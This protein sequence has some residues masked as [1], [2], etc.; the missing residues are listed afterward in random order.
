VRSAPLRRLKTWAALAALLI[1]GCA[2]PAAPPA[3]PRASPPPDVVTSNV[4][5]ADYA[6]SSTCAE[7]HPAEHEA[8]S[9]SAMHNMTR[10]I[11][12]AEVH[13]PFAGERFVMKGDDAQMETRDGQRYVT[14]HSRLDRATRSFRVTRVIG[15]RHREDFAGIEVDGVGGAPVSRDRWPK[16]EER[17][18]P[19]SFMLEGRVYRYKGYSVMTPDRPGLRPGAPWARTCIFCHNTEPYL[20]T[21][22][23][24]LAPPNARYQGEVVDLLLPEARRRRFVVTDVDRLRAALETELRLIGGK[25]PEAGP[26]TALAQQAARQIGASFDAKDLLEVGIGCESCH[27]GSREHVAHQKAR[28]SYLPHAPFLSTAPTAPAADARA[29]AIN[30]TCARCHQVLYSGYPFTWEGGLRKDAAPGGSHINSG[31]GRDFLLGACASKMACTDCHDPHSRDRGAIDKLDGLAGNTVCLRCHEKYTEP[32]ALQAHSH[33]D[34]GKEGASCMGCHMPRKNMTL[35]NRLG[36]YHRVGSPNDPTRVERDRPLECALCHADKRVAE[37]VETM[38]RWWNKKY[39]RGRLASL[40]GELSANPLRATVAR[41]KAHEQ[42]VALYLLGRSAQKD[43]APL[44]ATQ[45]TNPYGIL[46]YYARN[47]MIALLGPAPSDLDVHGEAVAITNA[48]AR[49]LSSQK[50]RPLAIDPEIGHR[51]S[52][53]GH[54]ATTDANGDD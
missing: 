51:A 52:G 35:D 13:A 41:G 5:R 10:S 4:V 17:V 53:I 24:A 31:E 18:L 16:G 36:R 39:D 37:L 42:A 23:G 49:W 46:R 44:V 22:L 45:L 7:C 20:D 40:Y 33:H 28:P 27:G 30:R 8:W 21:M 9:R 3:H 43:A 32:A 54:R 29:Q 26:V 14:I 48:A 11:A 50:L 25:A 15:G 12:E 2:H 47:A 6:G 38:E 1:A 19:I 34:P